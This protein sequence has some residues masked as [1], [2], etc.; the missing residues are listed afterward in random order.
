VK[1][2]SKLHDHFSGYLLLS[3]VNAAY[4]SLS[5]TP[6]TILAGMHI[7]LTSGMYQSINQ[8]INQSMILMV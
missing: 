2:I 1:K 7:V 5:S 4:C 6:W 3:D 8:S